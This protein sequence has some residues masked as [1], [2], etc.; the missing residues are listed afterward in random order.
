M[1]DR[2]LKYAIAVMLVAISLAGCTSNLNMPDTIKVQNVEN[3]DTISVNATSKMTVIPDKASITIGVDTTKRMPT[4]AQ[5]ENTELVNNVIQTL[6]DLGAEESN[7]KTYNYN[8]YEDYDYTDN[9]REFIGYTV[10]C[11]IDVTGI[12]VD[13][14]GNYI[15]SAVSAGATELNRVKYECSNYDEAYNDALKNAIAMATEKATIMA[16]ASGHKLGKATYISEGYQNTYARYVEDY[17]SYSTDELATN[18]ME[19]SASVD[20]MPGELE[21]SAEVNMSFEME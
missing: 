17:A 4:K 12:D 14:L 1:L 13:E 5:E 21:I 9:G 20:I 6:V 11:D 7:I 16:E 15:T 18:S 10:S 19:K 3:T 2:K 8:M